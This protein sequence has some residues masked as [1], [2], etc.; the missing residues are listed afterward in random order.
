MRSI[1]LNIQKSRKTV[2]LSLDDTIEKKKDEKS[3]PRISGQIWV[4]QVADYFLNLY[5]TMLEDGIS[6]NDIYN[7]FIRDI[8]DNSWD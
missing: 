8:H 7:L 5:P 6:G 3:P 1:L 2:I 4:D